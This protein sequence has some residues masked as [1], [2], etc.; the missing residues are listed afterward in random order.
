MSKFLEFYNLTLAV[1]HFYIKFRNK[2]KYK[3]ID[4]SDFGRFKKGSIILTYA[5]QVQVNLGKR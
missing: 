1:I 3:V 4:F 5:T 2:T